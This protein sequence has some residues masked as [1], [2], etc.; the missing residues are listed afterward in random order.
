MWRP[1]V[2][3]TYRTVTHP[4]V[5][6]FFWDMLGGEPKLGGAVRFSGFVAVDSMKSPKLAKHRSFL[7]VGCG[8]FFSFHS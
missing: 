5:G 2:G 4:L 8:R 7:I 6:L 1:V 3:N